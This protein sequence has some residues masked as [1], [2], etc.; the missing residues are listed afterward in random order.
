MEQVIAL[1]ERDD[2]RE[3]EHALRR[4]LKDMV[5][6]LLSSKFSR[7]SP[8]L[9]RSGN[10]GQGAHETRPCLQRVVIA[11]SSLRPCDQP[12]TALIDIACSPKVEA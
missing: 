9:G 6:L 12:C 4:E 11:R 10:L 5:G 7:R 3:Q 2:A 1:T 8:S